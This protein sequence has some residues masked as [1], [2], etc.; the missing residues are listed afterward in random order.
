MGRVE[1]KV[2][3]VTGGA[4]GIGRATAEALAREGASVVVTDIDVRVGE[5]VVEG[6]KTKG[7]TA[8]FRKQDV[9]DEA[10]WQQIV[11]ATVEEFGRLQV[12]L[13][14]FNIAAVGLSISITSGCAA[15]NS[16]RRGI[17]QCTAKTGDVVTSTLRRWSC[18]AS[19][20]SP[21]RT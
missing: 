11:E 2:A 21:R 4:A 8:V 5:S 9:V 15:W 3:I 19:P 12:Y 16:G 10:L 14:S 1:G 7:G 18:A 6:I 20:S 13:V 17:S